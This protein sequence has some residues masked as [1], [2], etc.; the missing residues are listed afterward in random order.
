MRTVF[1]PPT[2][3]DLQYADSLEGTDASLSKY[4]R[5]RQQGSSSILLQEEFDDRGV[6][7][8]AKYQEPSKQQLSQSMN[9]EM[10]I[11]L[12]DPF[13]SVIFS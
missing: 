2:Y 3:R 5:M 7:I 4:K 12:L 1:F 6:P 8:P 9:A 13:I 11:R 10:V